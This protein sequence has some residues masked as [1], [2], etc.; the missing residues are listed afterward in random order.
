MSGDQVRFEIAMA[1]RILAR[2]GCESAVAGHVSVRAAGEEAFWVSPFEYFDETTPDRIIKVSFDLDV[3]EGDWEPSPAIA[4][5]AAFYRGRPDV[6]SVIHTHSH[7]S[8]VLATTGRELGMYNDMAALFLDEQVVY[9]EDGISPPVDG[10][11][12]CELVGDRH[13]IIMKNHG[14]IFLGDSLETAT[15]EAF[16]FEKCA[17]IQVEAEMIGGT[18]HVR[19]YVVRGKEAYRKYYRPQMWAA[20]VR[21]MRR[22]E[23]DFFVGSEHLIA[24]H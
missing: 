6:N 4:F 16:T 24:V 22:D 20:A 19:P 1:R 18:E 7:Y 5:H 2:E 13:V 17:W 9:V 11:R 14:P 8:M 15:V 3:L 10:V 12:M 23:P 21:R